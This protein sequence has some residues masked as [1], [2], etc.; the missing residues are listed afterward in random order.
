VTHLLPQAVGHQRAMR[1]MVLGERQSARDL[2][3][4]GLV[5][6]VVPREALLPK[7]LEIAGAVAE[8][9]RYSVGR[10]KRLLVQGLDDRLERAL[11]LEGEITEAAFGRGEAAERVRRFTDRK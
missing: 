7:A 2:E 11:R 9:S 5:G 1:L 6:W 10:L 8:K 4:L 3:A